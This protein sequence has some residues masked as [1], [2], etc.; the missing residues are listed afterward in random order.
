MMYVSLYHSCCYRSNMK[1]FFGNIGV[2]NFNLNGVMAMVG[3]LPGGLGNIPL[4]ISLNK[5]TGF[6]SKARDLIKNPRLGNFSSLAMGGIGRLL[7]SRGIMSALPAGLSL[8][9]GKLDLP[10]LGQGCSGSGPESGGLD[11]A[12]NIGVNSLG[13]LPAF[14]KLGSLFG[15]HGSGF[16]FGQTSPMT[17]FDSGGLGMMTVGLDPTLY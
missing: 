5:V 15:Q 8:G 11:W 1:D 13:S 10:S 4:G 2:K 14:G 12:M 9:L 6:I 17:A 3:K 16:L 7:S